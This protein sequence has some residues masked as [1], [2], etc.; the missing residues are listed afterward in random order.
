[1]KNLARTKR[2]E[3]RARR[4]ATIRTAARRHLVVSETD[5]EHGMEMLKNNNKKIAR[6]AGYQFPIGKY[7]RHETKARLDD[8]CYAVTP[9][10]VFTNSKDGHDAQLIY[11]NP[12][13]TTIGLLTSERAFEFES[14]FGL[15]IV[16]P[17]R[18]D[19]RANSFSAD[20]RFRWYFK[21]RLRT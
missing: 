12:P 17:S 5:T 19:A 13:N 1:M 14:V 16:I 10:G 18:R 9:C 8:S 15:D 4:P 11:W 3:W 6:K 7:A 2:R 21:R 20:T